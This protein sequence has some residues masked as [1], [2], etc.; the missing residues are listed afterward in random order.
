MIT[1]HERTS[2]SLLLILQ[3]AGALEEGQGG[4]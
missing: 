4:V 1:V 2:P 3:Q